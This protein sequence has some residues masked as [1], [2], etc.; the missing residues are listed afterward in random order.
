MACR[1]GLVRRVTAGRV[2]LDGLRNGR[3]ALRGSQ[4]APKERAQSNG[5]VLVP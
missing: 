5:Y 4:A 3:F 1:L 2:R